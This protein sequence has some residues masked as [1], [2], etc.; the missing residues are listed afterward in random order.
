[1]TINDP[2]IAI[3]GGTGKEG[4]AIA[5]RFAKAGVHTIIGSRD[6]AK[7][8]QFA[9][10]INLECKI[11][12]VEGF[13]NCE[14]VEKADIVVLA[15]PYAAMKCTLEEIKPIVS[16]KV[17]IN[18]A[19]SLDPEKKS[20]AKINPA[21]SIAVE[22]QNFLGP[23]AKVVDAFQNICPTDLLDYSG[24]IS[25]DVLVVGADRATRDV[26]ICLIRKAN[27]LAYDAGPIENAVVVETMTAA[28]ISMN[29]RYKITGAGIHIT[30][31]PRS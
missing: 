30:G 2:S 18:I 1:M 12:S 5:A 27:I 23:Q 10:M 4:S 29:I 9:T 7:A 20:R 19:S 3:V 22:I 11:D 24:K 13:T 14:A 15:V 26:V 25:T 16:G 31:V 8:K 28:L 17:I 21:G 6:A